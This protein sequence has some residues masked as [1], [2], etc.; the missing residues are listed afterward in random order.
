MIRRRAGLLEGDDE[1]TTRTKIAE[2]VIALFRDAYPEL[3][4]NRDRVIGALDAEE[5]KFMRTLQNGL[6]E[7]EKLKSQF[8]SSPYIPGETAFFLY[9]SFGFRSAG[10]RRRYYHDNNE[11]ALIMWR[12]DGSAG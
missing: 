9:E 11:D 7:V 1:A 12:T 4:R 2:T 3:E 10:V 8:E 6:R 5:D